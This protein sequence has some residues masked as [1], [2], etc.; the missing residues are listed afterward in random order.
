MEKCVWLDSEFYITV[1]LP[2]PV[3]WGGH[4]F[5]IYRKGT[6]QCFMIPFQKM[7]NMARKAGKLM[8]L[9][10]D[11]KKY[12]SRAFLFR[13]GANRECV[14]K[15]QVLDGIKQVWAQMS[16]EFDRGLIILPQKAWETLLE[17]ARMI[18]MQLGPKG[19]LHNPKSLS[20]IARASLCKYARNTSLV[21][22]GNLNTR[23]ILRLAAAMRIL[24]PDWLTRM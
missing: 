6:N 7:R 8:Q 10:E 20:R 21:N 5:V 14:V 18:F 24:T 19:E 2:N 11:L 12:F 17:K 13:I 3:T 1:E 9:T 23:D 15:Y 4:N 16:W 22:F